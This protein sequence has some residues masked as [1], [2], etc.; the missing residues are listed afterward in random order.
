MKQ[1]KV[2]L[3]LFLLT[4][5]SCA[6]EKVAEN[7]VENEEQFT[8]SRYVR[9]SVARISSIERVLNYSGFVVYDQ[10]INIMPNLPGKIDRIAVR[11]G[12]Q[13]ASGELLAII[14]QNS[15][16]QSEANFTLAENNYRRAQNLFQQNAMDLRSFEETEMIYLNSRTAFETAKENLEVKAPFAG[17]ISQSNFRL[18]DNY[19]PM[20]GIPLFRIINNND[21]YI[22]VNVTNNDVRQLRLNQRVRVNVDSNI[23]DAYIGFIS[24]E[25]DRVTGLNR[26]RVEFRNSQRDLRNNQFATIE[27]IPEF[28]DNILV[29]PRTALINPTTVILAVEG[30][31]VYTQVQTGMSSRHFIE[32]VSGLNEGDIVLIEGVSG[33][34]NNA[35]IIPIDM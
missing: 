19:N 22:E 27:F 14:D 31:A 11:E 26:V 15:L 35:S 12:Q 2:I 9:T 33:L 5:L 10:A 23:I 18:N 21:I 25:N 30:K 7:P 34:E 8:G 29:I 32:I 3:L 6:K 20:M 1:L 13:V 17:T 24:P 28:K 16:L 4:I